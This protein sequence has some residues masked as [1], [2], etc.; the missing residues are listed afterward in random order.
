MPV[1]MLD[2]DAVVE[3]LSPHVGMIGQCAGKAGR[4]QVLAGAL[5]ST[6][7]IAQVRLGGPQ[8]EEEWLL[9]IAPCEKLLEVGGIVGGVEARPP[10]FLCELAIAAVLSEDV[11]IPALH[12]TRAPRLARGPD[13]VASVLQQQRE[14][15][16][17]GAQDAEQDAAFL[18]L[19]DIAARQDRAA[20]GRARWR[21]REGVV[22]EH[23][24]ARDPV[25]RWRE[26]GNVP[27][28]PCMHRGLVVRDGEQ[29]VG[30]R[31]LGSCD[32]HAAKQ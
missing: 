28:R 8:P 27:V 6:D 30:L 15:R 7:V 29:D 19:P 5:P 1:E 10:I 12:A 26:R 17:L 9:R 14:D 18:K 16:E 25:K 24:L 4:G 2:L 20:R 31:T 3:D 32:S 21:G 13:L 22:E 11:P 23:S